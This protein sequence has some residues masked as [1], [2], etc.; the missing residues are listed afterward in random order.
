MPGLRHMA[1][2]FKMHSQVPGDGN[3]DCNWNRLA[4]RYAGGTPDVGHHCCGFPSDHE[5]RLVTSANQPRILGFSR[6]SSGP[7]ASYR[8]AP[9]ISRRGGPNSRA[10][11]PIAF[12]RFRNQAANV[13]VGDRQRNREESEQDCDGATRLRCTHDRPQS[14]DV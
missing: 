6:N 9:S 8:R 1:A 3:S 13:S 12:H 7:T 10:C 2:N 11:P 4:D 5:E 14:G